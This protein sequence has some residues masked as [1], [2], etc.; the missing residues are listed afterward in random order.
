MENMLTF[1]SQDIVSILGDAGLSKAQLADTVK[2]LR[3]G[4]KVEG[5]SAEEAYDALNKYGHDLVVDAEAGT[6][7]YSVEGSVV[8]HVNC[9]KIGS[10]YWERR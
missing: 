10:G 9:R 5:K 3:G 8:S 7:S 4:R 2:Q 6:S 1:V